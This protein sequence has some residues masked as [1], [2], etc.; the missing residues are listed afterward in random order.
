M[1]ENDK[2]KRI[3][4]D[5]KIYDEPP[6]DEY[7]PLYLAIFTRSPYAH[8]TNPI[9]RLIKEGI[10]FAQIGNN[11][12]MLSDNF[13]ED[14]YFLFKT[15]RERRIFYY[16][17]TPKSGK[18]PNIYHG[19]VDKE[20]IV[21]YSDIVYAHKDLQFPTY[22]NDMDNDAFFYKRYYHT[23]MFEEEERKE[24]SKAWAKH[25]RASCYTPMCKSD[26]R[27]TAINKDVTIRGSFCMKCPLF[28]NAEYYVTKYID[29]TPKTKR[30][31]E[32]IGV[33]I[34]KHKEIIAEAERLRE[35]ERKGLI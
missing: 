6:S 27:C 14:V 23:L 30:K 13:A 26:D 5:H 11:I 19:E 29:G 3:E 24:L 7:I 12:R 1:P 33:R 17:L 10:I 20:R 16:T 18:E 21:L 28:Y 4:A 2:Y 25:K 15:E 35:E 22:G 9:K 34:P 8:N 32:Y 31:P